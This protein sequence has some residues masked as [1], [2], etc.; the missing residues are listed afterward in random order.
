[1]AYRIELS[2]PDIARYR[3]GNTGIDYVS[4]FDSGAAGPH[5]LVNALTHGNELCGAIALDHL[6]AS[7]VRP[8]RGKLTLCFANVAAFSTFDRANPSVSRFI[9]EDFNR[10]WD[11]ATLEGPRRSAELARAR[12]LRPLYESADLLLDLHSMQYATAP[13]MLIGLA[14]KTEAFA[15]RIGVPTLLVRDQGHAAGPRL[16]DFGVFAAHD[17]PHTALLAECGQHW[18]QRAAEVAI[19]TS[20]RFLAAAGVLADDHEARIL[21]APAP[22]QRLITVTDIITIASNRFVFAADYRGLEVIPTAG[23]VIGHDG[24][25][26]VRTP[27]DDCVLIMPSRRLGRG[28]TAVR[29]GRYTG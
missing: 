27:Y 28:Q 29:L 7:G 15:R 1:M 23:T 8:I 20:W 6:F 2:P 18:E 17:A 9:D 22:P 16:R 25:R 10:L 19:D 11:R 26:E 14:L 24:G 5:V 4:T 3:A 13:L 21:G 12:L